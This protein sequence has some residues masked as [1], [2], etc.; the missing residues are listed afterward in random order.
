MKAKK[1][2]TS[3]KASSLQNTSQEEQIIYDHLLECVQHQSAEEVIDGFR[4]LFI[5]GKDYPD[6]HVRIALAKIINSRIGE[7]QFNYILNR[8]CHILVNRWQMQGSQQVAISALSELFDQICP[9]TG[10]Y[11]NTSARLRELV[12]AFTKTDH[13]QRLKR[14]GRVVSQTKDTTYVGNL[15]TRYPYLYEHYLLSEDSN[16]EDQKTVRR[17]QSQSQQR[18][19]LDLSKYVT[20]KVR[21]VQG[22]RPTD[23][24]VPG[25]T[26]IT[27][28]SNP[29][30]LN[31][32]ELGMALKQFVGTVEGG[33]SYKDISHSFLTHSSQAKNYKS[34]KNDLYHYLITSVDTKYGRHKF[35]ESLYKR[36]QATLPHCDDKKPDEFL[37]LRTASQLLSFLVVESGQ[38][39]NHYVFMDLITNMGATPTVGLLLKVVLICHKVKPYLEKRFSIL[40]GHYESFTK[41][42]VPWLVR[43]LENMNIAFSVNFGKVDLSFLRQMM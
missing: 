39:P 35:N 12:I 25:K 33:Y 37:V 3:V 32:R 13:Y 38:N 31:D 22:T 28:M 26:I 1:V 19:E 9:P 4:R 8:C 7:E 18:F 14:M 42:G 21:Q 36:I 2:V 16:F 15:I 11:F 43:A 30:L 40:F 5:K 27:P 34:F 24:I 10:S 17:L 6:H 20:H 23:L 41:E 29:T